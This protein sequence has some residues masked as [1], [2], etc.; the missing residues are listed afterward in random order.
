LREDFKSD[1]PRINYKYKFFEAPFIN[2]HFQAKYGDYKNSGYTRGHNV[3]ASNY[4]SNEEFEKETYNYLNITPQTSS[5][6]NGL[7]SLLEKYSHKKAIELN[8]IYIITGPLYIPE[9]KTEN[10]ETY[11]ILKTKIIGNNVP[12]PTHYFKIIYSR[13]TNWCESYIIPNRCIGKKISFKI[14]KRDLTEIEKYAGIKIN[15]KPQ[16]RDTNTLVF[17]FE[18][19]E[20][21]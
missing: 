8:G 15:F 2:E 20:S 10:G 19:F 12:V 18:T 21:L 13:E 17:P 14:F 7:W 1:H 4:R 9:R 5:L 11:E 6:N 3:C 16:V